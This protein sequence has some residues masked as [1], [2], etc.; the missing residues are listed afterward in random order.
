MSDKKLK[1]KLPLI[2][3]PIVKK[4]STFVGGKPSIKSKIVTNKDAYKRV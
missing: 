2:D 1:V 3:K 4:V